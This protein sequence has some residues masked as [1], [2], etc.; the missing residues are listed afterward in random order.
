[1]SEKTANEVPRDVRGQFTKGNEAL[2]RDNADYAISLFEAALKREPAFYECRKALR[3][4]Q[5]TK[6]GSKGGFFKK[7]WSSASSSPLIAKAQLALRN[8]P[9]EAMAIAESVLNGDAN[10]SAAHRIIVEASEALHLPQTAV[11]S[12]E[13]LMR[14]SPRDKNVAIQFA[15]AVAD[16]GNTRAAERIL[17]EF[18]KQMPHDPEVSQAVKNLSARH[19]MGSSGYEKISQGEGS[20]RDILR[21][22]EEARSLEQENRVQ[23]SEDATARLISDYEA[24]LKKEPNNLKLVRQLAELYTQKNQ[25]D[26]AREL[27][28]RIKNSEMGND[29]S[30]DRAISET[31]SR[32]IE[33]QIASLD[34]TSPD[35]TERSAQLSADKLAFQLADCQQ[36]VEKFPTDLVLRFELGQLLFHAG[37]FSEAI[38]EFQRSMENPNKRIASM[39]YLAQCFAKRKMFD[40]AAEKLQ[41]AIKEKLIFDEEKKDLIYQLGTVLESQ[42]KKAEAI[43][44]FKQIYKVDASYRDV[45]TKIDKYYSGEA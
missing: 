2:L 34:P 12:L 37:R 16:T 5:Q 18:A 14:N 36:R 26:R 1:M 23:K 31:T 44:Q 33:H 3:A 6:S 30:L 28:Q 29:P 15:N 25:F 21:N 22:E 27:Y 7:A 45:E 24:R 9:G 11:M 20:Y 17:M 42:D 38:K 41:D 32:E 19:T 10:N 4:A 43:E 8:D 35:H 13:I 39:S 40:L